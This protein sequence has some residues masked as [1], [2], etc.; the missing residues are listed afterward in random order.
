VSE[1][2]ERAFT[3]DGRERAL[4]DPQ[5][6]TVVVRRPTTS[7]E[8]EFL[9]LHRAGEGADYAGDW[10][11]TSP[12]G[13]RLPGEPVYS[14]AVRELSEEAGID[15]YDV[16]AVDVTNRAAGGYQWAIFAVDVPHDQPV[17]LVDPEHDT[18]AWV[19]AD[20]A[21]KRVLPA[22]VG[23]NQ[24][25][26]LRQASFV[27]TSFRSMTAEDLP[28]VAG[29]WRQPHAEKWFHGRE[30]S[31]EDVAARLLP[32]IRGEMPTRMFVFEVDGLPVGYLQSY[33]VADHPEYAAKTQDPDAVAFDYMIGDPARVGRGLGTRMIWE[34][35]RDV[36]RRDHPDVVRF[37]ASPSHRNTGSLRVL[38]KCGFT[39]GLWIDEPAG[40][41]DRPDTEI[42]CTLD[43]R[44]YFG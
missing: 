16:W 40:L 34:F 38:E 9:L 28:L 1:T 7:G 27:R 5:G 15:G 13:C 12:A 19:T 39:Q 3:W 35:C 10:A 44:H 11:W 8:P 37:I 17:D 14:A 20:E 23:E 18:Y 25:T 29:W 4:D 21:Q 22:D 36:L 30:V 24:V 26:R 6:A 32:R 2:S 41:H 33:C 43:V 31:L 42:V